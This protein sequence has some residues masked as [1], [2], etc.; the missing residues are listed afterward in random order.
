MPVGICVQ[1]SDTKLSTIG[2]AETNLEEQ[3]LAALQIA[4]AGDPWQAQELL[5][6][7]VAGWE[8]IQSPDYVMRMQALR[9]LGS[10]LCSLQRGFEA[11]QLHRAALQVRQRHLLCVVKFTREIAIF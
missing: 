7:I 5:R 3:R 8:R 10:V 2:D 1:I 4:K 11:E 9:A 6:D